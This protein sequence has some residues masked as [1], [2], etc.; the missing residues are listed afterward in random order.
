MSNVGEVR[1]AY[2]RA[3]EVL[4]QELAKNKNNQGMDCG[5]PLV[6]NGKVLAAPIIM[7]H[8]RSG[9]STITLPLLTP[10]LHDGGAYR[11]AAAVYLHFMNSNNCRTAV[12]KVNLTI[13]T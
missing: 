5:A 2:S 10:P 8:L 1:T 13:H 9:N 3:L 12:P 6:Y 7:S 4:F 11:L